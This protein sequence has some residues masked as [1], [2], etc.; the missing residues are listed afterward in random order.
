V[1]MQDALPAGELFPGHA[2]PLSTLSRVSAGSSPQERA[3]L[4]AKRLP[5]AV[6]F[7]SMDSPPGPH[8]LTR[9]GPPLYRRSIRD[10]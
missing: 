2:H 10:W 9:P 5:A 1:R 8:I 4:L 3:R 7:R 6:K